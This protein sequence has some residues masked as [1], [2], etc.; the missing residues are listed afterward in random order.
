MLVS[1]VLNVGETKLEVHWSGPLQSIAVK[2]DFIFTVKISFHRKLLIVI[3]HLSVS[4]IIQ[5]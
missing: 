1:K 3:V 5:N 4:L 2:S